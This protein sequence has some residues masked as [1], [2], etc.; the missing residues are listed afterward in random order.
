MSCAAATSAAGEAEGLAGHDNGRPAA[1]STSELLA[2][3]HGLPVHVLAVPDLDHGDDDRRVVDGVDHAVVPDADAMEV[4]GAGELFRA[5]GARL[6]GEAADR[7][8]DARAVGL[9]AEAPELLRGAGLDP[10]I[11]PCHG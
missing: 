8:H 6:L 2:G 7:R 1:A 9:G 4:V 11:K 5:H 10:E 3:T